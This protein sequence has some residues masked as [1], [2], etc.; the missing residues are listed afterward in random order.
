MIGRIYRH[1]LRSQMH[2]NTCVIIRDTCHKIRSLAFDTTCSSIKKLPPILWELY[3]LKPVNYLSVS[4]TS[5]DNQSW[6]YVGPR[7]SPQ[8]VAILWQSFLLRHMNL[9]IS[10]P[11][12]DSQLRAWVTTAGIAWLPRKSLLFTYTNKFCLGGNKNILIIQSHWS[13][14]KCG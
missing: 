14:K 5:R 4:Y 6:G 1:Q 10:A 8:H 2:S 11:G 7:V 9:S 3:G 12:W 13:G